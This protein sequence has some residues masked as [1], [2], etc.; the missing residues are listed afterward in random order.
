MRVDNDVTLE[1]HAQDKDKIN[2]GWAAIPKGLSE[3][4]LKMKLVDP[5]TSADLWT[6][7]TVKGDITIVSKLTGDGYVPS[8][9]TPHENS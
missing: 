7:N 3:S 5:V 2:V 6:K 4:R 8:G 9:N 1:I